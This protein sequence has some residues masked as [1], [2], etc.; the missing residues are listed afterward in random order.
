[1]KSLCGRARFIFCYFRKSSQSSLAL[2]IQMSCDVILIFVNT[3]LL[4][5]FGFCV[6]HTKLILIVL[7]V[8]LRFRLLR[9]DDG[10]WWSKLR[11]MRN[12]H[13]EDTK[14]GKL[15]SAIGATIATILFRK[16]CSNNEIF[17]RRSF[18]HPRV[19]YNEWMDI[20]TN[21]FRR[22]YNETMWVMCVFLHVQKSRKG[23]EKLPVSSSSMFVFASFYFC[24]SIK[25][26]YHSKY[27]LSIYDREGEVARSN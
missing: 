26:Y 11:W 8:W 18:A 23:N 27:L 20:S 24:Y 3:K 4:I 17:E 13:A 14:N 22:R 6:A 15:N 1:M 2:S 9:A 5:L 16:R 12:V 25:W 7:I 21:L 10:Q 19:K